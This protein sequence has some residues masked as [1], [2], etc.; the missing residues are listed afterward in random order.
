MFSFLFHKKRDEVR[1]ILQGRMN[2]SFLQDVT[3][4]KRQSTR[5]PLS[6]VVWLVAWDADARE[7][8][9]HD[10]RPVLTKDICATGISLLHTDELADS[11]VVVGLLD[12][13]GPR[14]IRCE[15]VHSTSLGFGYFQSGLNPINLV[16]INPSDVD[17]MTERIEQVEQ[18]QPV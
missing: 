6:E 17:A 14:F 12:D 11:H 2:K 10:V 3:G 7:P 4:G 9:T 16:H 13:Q 5:G 15:V 1:R 8:S 18:P